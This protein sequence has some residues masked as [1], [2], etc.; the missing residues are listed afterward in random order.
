MTNNIGQSSCIVHSVLFCIHYFALVFWYL[1]CTWDLRQD[2]VTVDWTSFFLLP[3]HLPHGIHFLIQ[4]L[5]MIL[6]S[7]VNFT[8]HHVAQAFCYTCLATMCLD[9]FCLCHLD[10]FHH[11]LV[12]LCLLN[13]HDHI[14]LQQDHEDFFI[15]VLNPAKSVGTSTQFCSSIV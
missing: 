10:D 15:I 2:I 3:C 14:H 1:A 11:F 4:I 12:Y 7:L 8:V 13:S 5:F 6:I 9:Q